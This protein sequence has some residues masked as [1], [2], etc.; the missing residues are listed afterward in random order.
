MIKLHSCY[1]FDIKICVQ[2]VPDRGRAPVRPLLL[3]KGSTSIQCQRQRSAPRRTYVLCVTICWLKRDSYE[4][5]VKNL[6]FFFV[7]SGH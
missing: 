1:G 6:E 5:R 3:V 4:D 7:V 2:D